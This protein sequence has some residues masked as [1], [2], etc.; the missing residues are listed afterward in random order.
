MDFN[1]DGN[2]AN[3]VKG[4]AKAMA[5]PACRWREPPHC[6]RGNLHQQESD[7]GSRAG[8]RYQRQGKCHQEDAEQT[9]CRLGLAVYSRTPLGGQ[10][11]L[12]RSEEGS[13]KHHQH[14]A[15]KDIEYCIRRECV[16]CAG[17]ENQ[18]NGQSE[19]HINHYD[20]STIRPCITDAFLL[21]LLRFKKKLTVIG[22]MGHTQ[23]VKSANSPPANPV[24]KI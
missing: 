4:N 5:K 9:A 21:I 17:S 16:Q 11:Y 20:G 14:Q 15:E 2:R 10:R 6:R 24:I 12:E 19:R 1:Q 3:S 13:R 8:E 18:R 7:N 22:M 23:G